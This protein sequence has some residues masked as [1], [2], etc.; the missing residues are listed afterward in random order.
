LAITP[1]PDSTRPAAIVYGVG[2]AIRP[3]PAVDRICPVSLV[4][5]LFKA[6]PAKFIPY[7]IAAIAAC[8]LG[9]P[10]FP[11]LKGFYCLERP[12]Q[13]LPVDFI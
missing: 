5:P 1:A 6:V 4:T 3:L 8:P 9:P 10:I 2:I 12:N 13:L 7:P 11:L